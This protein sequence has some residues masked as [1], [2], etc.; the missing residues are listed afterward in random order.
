MQRAPWCTMPHPALHPRSQL[1]RRCRPGRAA[2]LQAC[3]QTVPHRRGSRPRGKPHRPRPP[4]QRRWRRSGR[5]HSPTR[6]CR[7]EPGWPGWPPFLPP[8]AAAPSPHF[9]RGRRGLQG[10]Q[11][12]GL[13]GGGWSCMRWQAPRRRRGPRGWLRCGAAGAE[14]AGAA[15]MAG[16]QAPLTGGG[17]LKIYDRGHMGRHEAVVRQR[18]S[19]F[20]HRHR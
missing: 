4:H 10:G 6:R 2:L 19:P 14:R 20:Q 3:H 13:A 15:A 5:W 12:G 18:H 17:R 9:R 8:S 16:G 1:T 11:A 7:S